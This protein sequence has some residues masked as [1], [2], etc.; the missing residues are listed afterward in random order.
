MKLYVGIFTNIQFCGKDQYDTSEFSELRNCEE[1]FFKNCYGISFCNLFSN[2]NCLRISNIDGFND[3]TAMCS[4]WWNL[5]FISCILLSRMTPP[6][7]YNR[8]TIATELNFPYIKNK[9]PHPCQPIKIIC[10]VCSMRNIKE[11]HI[12][13][14]GRFEETFEIIQIG[15]FWKWYLFYFL[16]QLLVS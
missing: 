1:Q 13:V 12:S 16:Y 3:S 6:H 9:C 10:M 4:W 8:W 15:D 11:F 2:W 5:G 7:D 14:F